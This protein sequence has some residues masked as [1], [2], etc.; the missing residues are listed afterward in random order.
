MALLRDF[1]TWR[2]EPAWAP[3]FA[4]FP[5]STLL[6]GRAKNI[7]GA[8]RASKHRLDRAIGGRRGESRLAAA[9]VAW[10]VPAR[11]AS[12]SGRPASPRGALGKVLGRGFAFRLFFLLSRPHLSPPSRF[13]F[14]PSL[15]FFFL[16]R[17]L[18]LFSSFSF[19]FYLCLFFLCLAYFSFLLSFPLVLTLR[20]APFFSAPASWDGFIFADC[21]AFPGRAGRSLAGREEKMSAAAK[22]PALGSPP[23]AQAARCAAPGSIAACFAK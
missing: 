23:A 4:R 1:A 10:P 18:H 8:R 20:L 5:A 21:P 17:L 13:A 15:R 2:F 16:L 14:S 19:C 6:A 3:G 11:P 7:I 9:Q 22:C 12:S